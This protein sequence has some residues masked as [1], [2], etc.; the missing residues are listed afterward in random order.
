MTYKTENSDFSLSTWLTKVFLV[1][2]TPMRCEKCVVLI[3]NL[4]NATWKKRRYRQPGLTMILH[5]NMDLLVF[6]IWC[7]QTW[8]NNKTAF[9]FGRLRSGPWCM[10]HWHTTTDSL[11]AEKQSLSYARSKRWWKIHEC[12]F[13][14]CDVSTT[15]LIL[16]KAAFKKQK[17]IPHHKTRTSHTKSPT[18]LLLCFY[19]FSQTAGRMLRLCPNT[20]MYVVLS[21]E[22]VL[23][24]D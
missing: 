18:Q 2:K 10:W 11:T 8:V 13:W 5:T 20:H 15:T 24:L 7:T 16:F 17:K 3:P 1:Q 4:F 21:G 9:C 23:W 14:T 6:Q 12:C 19:L 22:N